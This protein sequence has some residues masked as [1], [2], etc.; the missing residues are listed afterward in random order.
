MKKKRKNIYY[1][2]GVNDEVELKSDSREDIINWVYQTH[3]VEFY[4]TYLLKKTIED[5]PDVQDKI[6]EL[7]LMVCE[8]PDEKLKDLYAQGKHSILAY[9]TGIIH[10]QLITTNSKI[11]YKYEQHNK[12]EI[13]QDEL[14]WEKYND[15]EE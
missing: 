9:I 13:T 14:F 10:Q 5:N 1:P 11:Y 15:E 6:Q 3:M 4:T 12:T 8:L 2:H 7:Y